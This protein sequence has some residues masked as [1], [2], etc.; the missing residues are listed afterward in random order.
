[1]PDF[2][3]LTIGDLNIKLPI[4]QGGMGVR[5]SLAGLA[6]AVANQGGVGVIAT[7]GIGGMSEDPKTSYVELNREHLIKEIR[8]ARSISNGVIGINIMVA[9]SDYETLAKTA[10]E[11]KADLIISG[12]GL[13]LNLPQYVGDS[14]IKLIPIVSSG[15]ALSVICKKWKNNYNRLPD[16]V[17]VEGPKAGGHLGYAFDEVANNTTMSLEEIIKDVLPVANSFD[18]PIPVI[19]AGGIF[20]GYDIANTLK[21][22]VAGVQMATR[23]VCTEECDVHPAFKQMYLDAQEGDITLIKSPVGLPGK[24]LNNGFVKRINEGEKLP[25]KCKY[26]CLKS[27]NYRKAPYCIAE[28]LHQASI[29]NLENAFAFAGSN[30][31]KCDE[32]LSVENLVKKLREE[33]VSTL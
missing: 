18:K 13:P 16:A 33:Y 14:N 3:S 5:I 20:D 27:C 28:V 29:G 23:F 19:A 6:G 7:A 17:I 8:K 10:V 9:L 21:C 12:A 15:R 11:E 25:F 2:P 24:V 22:G 1:M 31:Y 30:A 32:I 4:I 26:Q